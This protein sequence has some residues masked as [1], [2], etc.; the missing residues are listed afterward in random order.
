MSVADSFYICRNAYCSPS[1]CEH[2]IIGHTEREA[3]AVWCAFTYIHQLLGVILRRNARVDGVVAAQ[4]AIMGTRPGSSGPSPDGD[5]Q[6]ELRQRVTWMISARLVN[7]PSGELYALVYTSNWSLVGDAIAK[8]KADLDLHRRADR[9][10]EPE[11]PDRSHL[12][13]WIYVPADE[14]LSRCRF[15]TLL[16]PGQEIIDVSVVKSNEPG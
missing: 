5:T 1:V 10:M 14:T 3:D 12:E 6:R 7:A 11:G 13:N 4:M 15:H 9:G 8:A 2:E 16:T